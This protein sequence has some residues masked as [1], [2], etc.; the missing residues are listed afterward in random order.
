MDIGMIERTIRELECGETTFEA[1]EKLAS[2]YI[3]RNEVIK[4]EDDRVEQELNDILPMYQMYVRTKRR[5]QK[6]EVTKEAVVESMQG[7]CRE[8][9]EFIHT[10]YVC[11]DLSEEREL[12]KQMTENL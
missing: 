3:I 4:Q 12:L 7:V 1:C 6:H 10:L 9:E 5:Y 8:I 2:L 11:S